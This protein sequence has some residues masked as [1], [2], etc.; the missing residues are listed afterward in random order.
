[1]IVTTPRLSNMGTAGSPNSQ[2]GSMQGVADMT[3]VQVDGSGT[4][5]P[6]S[7]EALPLA[8]DQSTDSSLKQLVAVIEELNL[9]VKLL[10]SIISK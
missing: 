8:T 9:N 7:V 2:V 4:V 6:I 3:P 10:I 5:Q 1:M